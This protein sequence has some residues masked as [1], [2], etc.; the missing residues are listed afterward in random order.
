M[1]VAAPS[2]CNMTKKSP[3][4]SPLTPR[5]PGDVIRR[6]LR[7]LVLLLL[8]LLL[9]CTPNEAVHHQLSL[10][11][12][13]F[14]QIFAESLKRVKELTGKDVEFIKL[15]LLD[16][17]GLKKLFAEHDFGAVIH[18]AGLKVSARGGE[19][20]LHHT[21]ARNHRSIHCRQAVHGHSSTQTYHASSL[22]QPL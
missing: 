21:T 5:P 10:L 14:Y 17:A 9:W 22:H 2:L 13:C 20:V 7:T 8:L 4:V 3:S 11:W 16:E 15:D 19:I 6:S 1:P 18:F 12:C